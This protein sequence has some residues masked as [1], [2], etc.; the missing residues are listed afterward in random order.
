MFLSSS[1]LQQLLEAVADGVCLLDMQGCISFWNAGAAAL[2]GYG[3]E[4]MLSRPCPE[5]LFQFLPP[6]GADWKNPL[7]PEHLAQL[8][9]AL[10]AQASLRHKAGHLLAVE[11]AVLPL[12]NPTGL[13]LGIAVLFRRHSPTYHKETVSYLAKLAYLDSVSGVHSRSYGELKMRTALEEMQQTNVPAGILLV[14]LGS[15][16]QVNDAFGQA[17]GDR[18][19]QV[20]GR[21]LASL[22][23]PPNLVV[24]WQ[25]AVFVILCPNGK[26]SLLLLLAE[27][28]RG[29]LAQAQPEFRGQ[30]LPLAAVVSGAVANLNDTPENLVAKAEKM[31]L[32]TDTNRVL[33]ADAK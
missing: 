4:E 17:A 31:L 15:L 7:A 19:L 9:Q 23:E 10:S 18:L 20:V 33:V 28:I 14:Q 30:A 11:A 3:A 29:L 21:T 6:P 25:S 12:S 16:K 22:V 32:Q 5:M 13:Q 2:S 26:K 24:R 1:S 27:R 8:R